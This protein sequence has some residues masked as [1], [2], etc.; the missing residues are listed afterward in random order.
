MFSRIGAAPSRNVAIAASVAWHAAIV[1]AL[2]WAVRSAPAREAVQTKVEP[3]ILPTQIV[4]LDKAGESKGG[5][6]DGGRETATPPGQARRVGTDRLTVAVAKPPDPFA[7][8]PTSTPP[9]PDVGLDIPAMPMASALQNM[10]GTIQPQPG[11]ADP[12]ALGSGRNGNTGSQDGPGEGRG[13]GPGFGNGGPGGMG[14]GAYHLGRSGVAPPIPLYRGI[15]RYTSE[16]AQA[17]VQGSVFV[18]CIVQ[19]TGRCTDFRIVRSIEPPFG[20]DR[21]AIAAAGAWRFKPGTFAGEQVP[22]LVTIEVSFS[23]R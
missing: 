6:L 2:I 18:E 5:G 4:F 16:A 14:D 3:L 8:A 17:R 9:P 1:L 21:E 15:P 22:V 19:R 23:I 7:V 20:L 12:N 13:R 10:P 11:P